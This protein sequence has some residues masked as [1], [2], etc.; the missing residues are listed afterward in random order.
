LSCT[1]ARP[2]HS[3]RWDGKILDFS[4]GPLIMGILNVTPDSFYPAGR[5]ATLPEAVARAAE[6]LEAGADIIDVGGES[7]RPGSEALDAE[8]ERA[9]VVPVITEIR[10]RFDVP[11]SVDTQKL[12]VAKAALAHGA[13]MI[14]TVSGLKDDDRFAGF[15]AGVDVPVVL[16]H[17]RGNPKT[18]QHNPSYTHTI[19]EISRELREL[20]RHARACGI[21]RDRII[22][23]PGIG[24]GKRVEDN[25]RIINHLDAFKKLGYPL[26][27]GISRKSFIGT[28]LDRPV[29]E[30]L[31]G[32][33][34]ANVMAVLKGADIIRVHDVKE[35][36]EMAVMIRAI[37]T[38]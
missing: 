25:L 22:L 33:V 10:K 9:R 14:N 38:S 20:I 11:I 7:T 34:T 17:M 1:T 4:K 13:D 37:T 35:A 27:I 23:D 29:A 36:R 3:I 5:T 8:A 21:G 32:T 26:L 16:M 31:T 30:R 6:M 2:A 15:V 19:S 28:V 12:E 18:M 24:F